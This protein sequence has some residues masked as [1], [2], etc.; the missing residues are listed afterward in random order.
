MSVVSSLAAVGSYFNVSTGRSD[1]VLRGADDTFFSLSG[2][3]IL[4]GRG[5]NDTLRDDSDNDQL[6]GGDGAEFLDGGSQDDLLSGGN[7]AD[8][9]AGGSGADSF[10]WSS[11]TSGQTGLDRIL[12]FNGRQGD[13]IAFSEEAE[14]ATGIH[15]YADFLA[16]ARATDAGVFLAFNG[17]DAEGILIEDVLL[18]ALTE[19]DV[20]FGLG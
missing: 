6:F 15:S 19:S 7:G 8:L 12:D 13:R 2:K 5:G 9:L 18:S 16:A 20:V 3:D 4:D 10:L 11:E 14:D 1:D 17:S